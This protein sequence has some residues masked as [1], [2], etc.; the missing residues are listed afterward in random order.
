MAGFAPTDLKKKKKFLSHLLELTC[1]QKIGELVMTRQ[2]VGIAIIS[3]T[4]TFFIY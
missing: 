3:P 1:L 2:E 4:I